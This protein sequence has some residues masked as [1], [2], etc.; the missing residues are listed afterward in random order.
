MKSV[1]PAGEAP[2]SS[3]APATPTGVCQSPGAG[4]VALP[5]FMW[6]C[7]LLSIRL[8]ELACRDPQKTLL[9]F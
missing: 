7:Q 6:R 3:R 1:P 4:P 9:E 2:R 8:S 5:P